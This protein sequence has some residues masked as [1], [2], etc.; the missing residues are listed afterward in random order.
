[1]KTIITITRKGQ[2]TLPAAMRRKLGLS[3]SG[4]VLQV[5]F[6]E[7]KG[8]IVI[9]KPISVSELSNRVSSYI[10]P[11]TEPVHNVDDYY[12]THRQIEA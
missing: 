10:K 8:E 11:G 1:M 2:T 4:G 3:K 6:N 7:S 9:S 5:D 12:Q